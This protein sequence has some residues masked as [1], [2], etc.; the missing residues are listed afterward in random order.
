[1]AVLEQGDEEEAQD[2]HNGHWYITPDTVLAINVAPPPRSVVI[3]WMIDSAKFINYF[4]SVNIFDSFSVNVQLIQSLTQ[5]FRL[6]QLRLKVLLQILLDFLFKAEACFAVLL[7][8]SLDKVGIL[9]LLNLIFD[10]LLQVE[11]WHGK[12]GH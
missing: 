12:S 4:V 6:L 7:S 2:T 10:I 1:M 5:E 9:F 3:F 11:P 8:N